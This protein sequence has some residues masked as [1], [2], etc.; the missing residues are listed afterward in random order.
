MS[1]CASRTSDL[2]KQLES[3]SL[4]ED[5][6]TII[7]QRV[8]VA[9][10]YINDCAAGCSTVPRS[11]DICEPLLPLVLQLDLQRK[12]LLAYETR[13]KAR[14]VVGFTQHCFFLFQH[15]VLK[16]VVVSQIQ[17]LQQVCPELTEE[18]AERALNLC[19]GR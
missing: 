14:K 6:Q 18:E 12:M 17:D 7:Q 1:V 13:E 19:N 15:N 10:L 8:R 4:T 5:E 9:L 2:F 3:R 11:L 16:L